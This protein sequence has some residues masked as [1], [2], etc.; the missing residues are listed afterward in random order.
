MISLNPEQAALRLAQA[1][2]LITFKKFLKASDYKKNP[3]GNVRTFAVQ[4]GNVYLRQMTDGQRTWGA[5]VIS[6]ALRTNARTPIIQ[7]IKDNMACFYLSLTLPVISKERSIYVKGV[8]ATDEQLNKL[9][10]YKKVR[11]RTRVVC[12]DDKVREFRDVAIESGATF[13]FNN[14]EIE[15]V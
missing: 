14:E 1:T 8:L 4:Q 7:H 3:L 13:I 2:G 5:R 6:P 9:E 15:V 11:K 10:P 12:L